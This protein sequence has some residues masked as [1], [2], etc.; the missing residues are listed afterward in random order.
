[1]ID[2]LPTSMILPPPVKRPV[3]GVQTSGDGLDV[4][5]ICT[6]ELLL[7][8]VADAA[9]TVMVPV[10][11]PKGVRGTDTVCALALAVNIVVPEIVTLGADEELTVNE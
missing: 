3:A 10:N 1:M 11:G 8:S 2:K 5:T 4:N 7:V 6:V 9:V